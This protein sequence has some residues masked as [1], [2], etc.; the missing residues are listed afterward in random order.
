MNAPLSSEDIPAGDK[1][2]AGKASCISLE[3]KRV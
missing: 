2:A 3:S 1:V